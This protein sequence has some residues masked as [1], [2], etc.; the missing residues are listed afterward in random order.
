MAW[1]DDR[2]GDSVEM[3]SMV[4]VTFLL[5]IFFMVTA[6]FSLQKSIEMPRQQ[7]DGFT[8]SDEPETQA[9]TVQVDQRGSVLVMAPQW[10]QETLGKQ[11][12]ITTLKRATAESKE[13]LRLSV[14]VHELAQLNA[15]VDVLDAGTTAGFAAVQVTQVDHL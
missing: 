9:V 12:L 3:T 10:E 6:S 1:F 14:Q 8:L 15:L 7:T 11:Q 4:D 13:S 5:L 2:K